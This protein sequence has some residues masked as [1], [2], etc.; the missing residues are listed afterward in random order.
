[1]RKVVVHPCNAGSLA[2]ALDAARLGL[3]IPLLIGPE[4]KIRSVAEVAGQGVAFRVGSGLRKTGA[5]LP[6]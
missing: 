2:G 6:S 5:W 1:M 3:M 4:T